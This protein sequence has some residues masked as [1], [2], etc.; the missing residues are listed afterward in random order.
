M[1]DLICK[2]YLNPLLIKDPY[3]TKHDLN[4]VR[5]PLS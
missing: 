5:Y 3:V 2:Y 1:R 4:E